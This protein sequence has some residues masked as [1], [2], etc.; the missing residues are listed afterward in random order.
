MQQSEGSIWVES[1]HQ[2]TEEDLLKRVKISWFAVDFS[3]SGHVLR[4][5]ATISNVKSLVWRKL[6]C[7]TP[8]NCSFPVKNG[9]F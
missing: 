3:S 6:I 4:E 2:G 1:S 8:I 7:N 5:G 9:L